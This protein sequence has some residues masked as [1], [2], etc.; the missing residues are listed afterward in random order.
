MSICDTRSQCRR[1][2][3]TQ[4]LQ[5]HIPDL[6]VTLVSGQS[7]EVM[8]AADVVLL[9]SGTATLEAALSQ[10][11][12]VVAYRMAACPGGWCH[13]WCEHRMRP[14]P[15]SWRASAGAGAAAGGGHAAAMAQRCSPCCRSRGGDKQLQGFR[16]IHQR[17]A[18]DLHAV[19]QLPWRTGAAAMR[20]MWTIC[21]KWITRSRLAGVD[22][23]GVVRWRVTWLPLRLFWIPERPIEGLRDSKKLSEAR[24]EELAMLIRENALAWSVARAS[25][26]EIDEMNILQASLLAMHRAVQALDPSRICAGGR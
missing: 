19:R 18:A 11:P 15:M 7:R 24:R 14:C 3:L 2:E 26:A 6:P 25:V 16:A 10:R 9:A 21:L 12:M 1:A 17:I 5:L 4:I 22:E 13:G 23:V 8:A 20:S